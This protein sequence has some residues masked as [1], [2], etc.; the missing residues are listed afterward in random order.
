MERFR[1][2]IIAAQNAIQKYKEF[3]TA[4]KRFGV[5]S[6]DFLEGLGFN[7]KLMMKAK[8][9]FLLSE[10]KES[11]KLE[12][13]FNLAKAE[14]NVNRHKREESKVKE[15]ERIAASPK[16]RIRIFS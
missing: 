12:L 4:V 16:K 1:A 14:G 9:K 7:E 11:K 2:K 15:R 10:W 8:I 5:S 3:T 6:K 13:C